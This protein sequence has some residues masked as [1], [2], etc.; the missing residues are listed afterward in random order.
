MARTVSLR[1][2]THLLPTLSTGPPSLT[3]STTESAL[4]PASK[5]S[6]EVLP[7]AEASVG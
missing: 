6:W 7:F 5:G 1:Q 3:S 4:L 2:A